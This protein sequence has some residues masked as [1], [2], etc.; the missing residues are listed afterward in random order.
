MRLIVGVFAQKKI[1]MDKIYMDILRVGVQ[2]PTWT[3]CTESGVGVIWK[4]FAPLSLL[5]T[6]YLKSLK[7]KDPLETVFKRAIKKKM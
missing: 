4:F 2:S 3:T 7:F 5:G 6:T 1:G